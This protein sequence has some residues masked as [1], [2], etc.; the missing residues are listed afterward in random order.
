MNSM[1]KGAKILILNI[2]SINTKIFRVVQ[3]GLQGAFPVICEIFDRTMPIPQDMYN[4]TKH[5]Y[6]ST[7]ILKRI[8]EFTRD[9]RT[10]YVLGLIDVDLYIPSVDFIF[11]EAYSPGRVAVVSLFRLKQESHGLPPDDKLYSERA[12]KEAVHEVGHMIG[13]KHCRDP[14]CVMWFSDSI[15]ETDHKKRWLCA[16]CCKLLRTFYSKRNET[17]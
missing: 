8:E 12:V 16:K 6:H 15:R 10:D 7:K 13:L 9:C 1:R 11:G 2:G 4:P 5:Q 14:S 17:T 3:N